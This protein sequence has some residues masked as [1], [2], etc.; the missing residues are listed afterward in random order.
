MKI[1]NGQAYELRNSIPMSFFLNDLMTID[2]FLND[3]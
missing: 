1:S 2:F 3:Y